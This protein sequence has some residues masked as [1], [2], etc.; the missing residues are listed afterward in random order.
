MLKQ[1]IVTL[2]T[3]DPLQAQL[4]VEYL[5]SNDRVRFGRCCMLLGYLAGTR[6]PENV[7]AT[8]SSVSSQAHPPQKIGLT[9]EDLNI[10]EMAPASVSISNSNG[11]E[12]SLQEST[13][14]MSQAVSSV[15]VIQPPEPIPKED[16]KTAAKLKIGS[17][18]FGLD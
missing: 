6:Q 11:I 14:G 3:S 12:G 16:R 8:E 5:A 7:E 9:L 17:S 2:D 4:L 15:P 1:I 18:L 10:A 13:G